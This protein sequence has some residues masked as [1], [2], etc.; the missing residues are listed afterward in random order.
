MCFP[1]SRMD[2]NLY[3]KMNDKVDMAADVDQVGRDEVR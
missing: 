3:D 2:D 1:S